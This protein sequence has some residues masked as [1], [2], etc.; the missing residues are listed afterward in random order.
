MPACDFRTK[1]T[2]DRSTLTPNVTKDEAVEK[3][4]RWMQ[5]QDAAFKNRFLHFSKEPSGRVSVH[6]FR[7]VGGGVSVSLVLSLLEEFG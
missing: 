7:K 6:D 2:E 4:G 5:Q 3:L 1:P